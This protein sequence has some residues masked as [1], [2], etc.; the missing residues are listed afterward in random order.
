[1]SD[2]PHGGGGGGR[3]EFGGGGGDHRGRG[4]GGGYQGGGGGYHGGGGGGHRGG[5]DRGGGDRGGH[6]HQRSFV[7]QKRGRED[8]PAE[9]PKKALVSKLMNLC[10]KPAVSLRL[11]HARCGKS[12]DVHF[13][14]V[15]ALHHACMAMHACTCTKVS[16]AL[17]VQGGSGGDRGASDDRQTAADAAAI[18]DAYK[19]CKRELQHKNETV[20]QLLVDCATELG[21]KAPTYALIAG[22]LNADEPAWGA[23]LLSQ[24]AADLTAALRSA[25]PADHDR[26]RLLLRFAACLAAANVTH[27]S[28]V[29]GLLQALVDAAG[30]AARAGECRVAQL[31]P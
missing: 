21:S 5:Y 25:T 11:D 7:G 1:M 13:A 9:D 24:V 17:G 2:R 20:Y 18:E 15:H 16:R 8:E 19:L 4:G 28:G 14:C 6:R 10:D 29:V 27:P 26:A 12:A 30:A 31:L 3:R 23:A 22:L